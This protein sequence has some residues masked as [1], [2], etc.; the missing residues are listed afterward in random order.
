MPSHVPCESSRSG[1]RR[2]HAGHR[3]ANQRTPAG[4]IPEHST[5]T[6]V[7]MS[8]F[9]LPTRQQRPQPTSC[10]DCAPSSRSLPDAS[11]TPFPA[12][13][14]TT[15][16]SQCSMRWFGAPLR[17]ATPE[18]LPPSSTQ[19]RTARTLPT[20]QTGSS[21]FARDTRGAEGTRTPDPHTARLGFTGML[22]RLVSRRVA[23]SLWLWRFRSARVVAVLPVPGRSWV[24]SE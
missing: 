10:R 11:R 22:C 4:L 23:Q 20:K 19:H 13:L 16:F 24:T 15:V 8:L 12:S 7:L 17:R 2:L 18:G 3:P 1:S 21:P 9:P 6:P 14:T 5:K